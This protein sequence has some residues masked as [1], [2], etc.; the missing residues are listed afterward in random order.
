M[1][2]AEATFE[3]ELEI[4]ARSRDGCSSEIAQ[5][6]CELA[7]ARTAMV[8]VY[9]RGDDEPFTRLVDLERP[10]SKASFDRR[11]LSQALLTSPP[12]S[13]LHQFRAC[14]HKT[15]A[16]GMSALWATPV[17]STGQRNTLS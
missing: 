4:Q 12:V 8:F 10:V 1:R 7:D 3:I 2:R 16:G 6:D 11:A 14:T 17:V 5:I 13:P 9:F 15:G